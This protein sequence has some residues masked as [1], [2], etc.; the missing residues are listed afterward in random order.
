MDRCHVSTTSLIFALHARRLY[1]QTI[2]QRMLLQRILRN[3]TA[4][5][6]CDNTILLELL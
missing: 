4:A 5:Q 1:K 2:K 3:K 6:L